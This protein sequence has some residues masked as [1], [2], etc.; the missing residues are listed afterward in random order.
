MK[1]LIIAA[2]ILCAAVG[3]AQAKEWKNVRIGIEGAYPPFSWTEPN[4]EVKGFDIDIAN[5]LC[6][7]MKVKCTLVKQDWDG[8]IPA[9]LARK[10][11]AIIA[12]MDITDERKKKV[13][14]S[15]K[16]QHIPARFA[17][18]KGTSIELTEAFMS[19]KRIGV[20]RATSMDTYVTDNFPKAE[21]K[22]YGTADEAY[23]DLKA[24][25]IDYVM[26]DSAAISE[27]LLNKPGGDA[28]EFVGPKLNDP[29][30]FG[31]GAG[32]AM[33]KGDTELHAKF[34]EAIKAIRAN[35]KYKELQDKYFDFDIYGDE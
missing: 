24:G 27:G 3:T 28:F 12:T 4:G 8:I 33:R 1:K 25:R 9:L 30:W 11:D 22:R 35:G 15:D 14:F 26:I 17:A 29:K 16:Y 21:V 20:Q 19:G 13:A 7:E 6:E 5:A 18:K 23:L 10:Y 2:T 34:N 32:I 31:E